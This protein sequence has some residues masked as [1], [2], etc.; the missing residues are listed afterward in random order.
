MSLATNSISQDYVKVSVLAT[1]SSNKPCLSFLLPKQCRLSIIRSLI[2]FPVQHGERGAAIE[3]V[4]LLLLFTTSS[5]ASA[6][7]AIAALIQDSQGRGY[8]EM[9][10][11]IERR[12]ARLA[13]DFP[14]YVLLNCLKLAFPAF[15]TLT[16]EICFI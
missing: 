9:A 13:S 3:A 8:D 12:T 11:A 5:A 15:T 6:A 2:Q 7:A 1:L 16:I 10:P 14:C 4:L